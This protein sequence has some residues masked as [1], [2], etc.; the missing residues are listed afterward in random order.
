MSEKQQMYAISLGVRPI[1]MSGVI[2]EEKPQAGVSLSPLASFLYDF[3][4][5][6]CEIDTLLRKITKD[7][8]AYCTAE[9]GSSRKRG[10]LE[11]GEIKR[12]YYWDKKLVEERR[13]F[14]KG[15]MEV[16]QVDFPIP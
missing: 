13:F 7:A 15:S 3:D 11:K 9:K 2:R 6:F 12:D 8:A 14:R 4:M 5:D 10:L 1:N 16:L